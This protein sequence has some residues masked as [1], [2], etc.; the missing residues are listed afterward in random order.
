MSGVDPAFITQADW[1]AVS[2]LLRP[3]WMILGSGL[4]LAFSLLLAHGAIPS[5]AT[6]RDIPQATAARARPPLYPAAAVF[7]ALALFCVTVLI[8]RLDVVST[9]FY[10]GAI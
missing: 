8:D 6:S 9:I 4:G 7:L 1:K 5:L 10:R 3:I 2:E